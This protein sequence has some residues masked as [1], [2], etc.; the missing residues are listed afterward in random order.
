MNIF[1]RLLKIGQAE[2]HALVEKMEDP[3]S[4]TEQGLKI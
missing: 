1:K 4:L 3:I 2:I